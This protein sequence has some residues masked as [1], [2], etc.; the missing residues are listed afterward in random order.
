MHEKAVIG[1]MLEPDKAMM[2]ATGY[3]LHGYTVT[4]KETTWLLIIKVNS[5]KGGRLVAFI[6]C[7]ELYQCFALWHEAM[8]SN[9]FKLT[10]RT[11]QYA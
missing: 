1:T 8:H 3:A 4:K 7:S 5:S 2:W 10:W 9:S 11:D 6:E